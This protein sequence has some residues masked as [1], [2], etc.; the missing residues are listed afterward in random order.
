MLLFTGAV[1]LFVGLIAGIFSLL[2][3]NKLKIREIW[4]VYGIEFLSLG[5]ILVPAYFGGIYFTLAIVMLAAVSLTEYLNIKKGPLPFYIKAVCIVSGTSIIVLTH[6]FGLVT[7]YISVPLTVMVLLVISLFIK[8]G[9]RIVADIGF[10]VLGITYVSIFFSYIVVIRKMENGFLLI[11]FMYGVSEIYDSF[12]YLLGKSF[13]KK[14]IFPEISP[15]KTYMG[16]I[17]GI[18]AAL[19]FSI[20][21]NHFVTQFTFP[22]VL[23]GASVIIIFTILGDLVSSKLKRTH[24][25]KDFSSLVPKVGGI[26][27]VYDALIFVSPAF[28]YFIYLTM[29]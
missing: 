3:K 8:T 11:F 12:A 24:D 27:D 2:I 29:G 1:F 28:Y 26:L 19:V 7:V 21:L 5:A 17:V 10:G 22:H 23:V 18:P 25:V 16:F 14:K 20:I 13:G 9:E 15:N 4:I 6:F